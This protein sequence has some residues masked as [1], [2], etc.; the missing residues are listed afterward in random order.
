MEG[1]QLTCGVTLG[2]YTTSLCFLFPPSYSSAAPR[3]LWRLLYSHGFPCARGLQGRLLL[4]HPNRVNP[5]ID[6]QSSPW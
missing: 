2:S 1:L 3:E 4:S 5:N 6:P